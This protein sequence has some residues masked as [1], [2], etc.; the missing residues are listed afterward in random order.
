ML[1]YAGTGSSYADR[2]E[3]NPGASTGHFGELAKQHSLHIMCGLIERDRAS[4]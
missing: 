4:D 1:T 2:A 3:T